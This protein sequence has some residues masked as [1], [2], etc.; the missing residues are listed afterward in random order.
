MQQ[1]P[2]AV[3]PANTATQAAI[4]REKQ[5]LASLPSSSKAMTSAQTAASKAAHSEREKIRDFWLGLSEIE[6][7]ALVKIEKESVLRKMKDQ[8]RHGC[9]CA[10]C[11]RKRSAI[12]EELEVLYDAYYEEL[13]QYA[14]HQ[15]RY[16]SSGGTIPPPPGPGPF[17]GSVDTSLLPS[18]TS[19]TAVAKRTQQSLP[20]KSTG[21]TT[22][23][24]VNAPIVNTANTKNRN[25]SPSCPHHAHHH[26]PHVHNGVKCNGHY[27]DVPQKVAQQPVSV[28]EDEDDE[29]DD[30]DEYDEDDEEEEE[31][32]EEDDD[33]DG[34]DG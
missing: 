15:Q 9:S 21:K 29:D 12:E 19:T 10:V 17:P 11:G 14:Y 5:Q 30:D 22:N 4:V 18:H 25:H 24:T 2:A 6:R 34:Y 33:E 13:E 1:M 16:Q 28:S 8:Q 27:P 31:E 7:R 23:K 32:E 3:R 20:P 26:G